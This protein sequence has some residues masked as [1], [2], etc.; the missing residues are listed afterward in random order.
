MRATKRWG[1][2]LRSLFHQ[3]YLTEHVDRHEYADDLPEHDGFAIFV[4]DPTIVVERV[5]WLGVFG[6][7][8]MILR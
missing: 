6:I 1:R 5:A 7:F 8:V 2:R 4:A 3:L